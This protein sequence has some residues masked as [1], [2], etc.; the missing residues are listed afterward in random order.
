MD[1]W[2]LIAYLVC[3][4]VIG[5]AVLLFVHPMPDAARAV[6]PMPTAAGMPAAGAPAGPSLS[7]LRHAAAHAVKRAAAHDAGMRRAA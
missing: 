3:L 1:I 2:T 4:S 7:A 5:P 6:L